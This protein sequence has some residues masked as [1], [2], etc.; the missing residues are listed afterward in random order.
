MRGGNLLLCKYK[1]P[2][3]YSV[4]LIFYAKEDSKIRGIAKV[5]DI[6]DMPPAGIIVGEG[7]PVC[8]ALKFGDNSRVIAEAYDTASK[9]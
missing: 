2:R 7:K 4:K 9:L 6:V 5:E 3:G 8:S 1:R